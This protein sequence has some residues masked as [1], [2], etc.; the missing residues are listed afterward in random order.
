MA[1]PVFEKKEDIPKGFEA[2]YE[3]KEGKF[4]PKVPDVKGAQT[5]LEAER[6]RAD[7][8]KKARVDAENKLAEARRKETAREGNISDEQLTKLREEDAAKRKADLEPVQSE[9]VETKA[10]LRK[11]T[12]VDRLRTLGTESGWLAG[13]I[14][15]AMDQALKRVDLAEGSDT[16]IVVKDKD[17]KATTEKVEDFLKVRLKKEKP[18]LYAGSGARGSGTGG[19]DGSGAVDDVPAD[20]EQRIAAKKRA[21]VAG[22][23]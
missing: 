1:F 9:L 2:D 22:A 7:D 11:I 5:A 8:E 16:N 3:E 10:K 14:E 6:K 17:G 23:F 18:W 13:R 20:E 12:L 21:Q 4:H 19:S 15:D